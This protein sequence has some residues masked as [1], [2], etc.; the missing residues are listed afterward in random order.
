[1]VIDEAIAIGIV[2]VRAFTSDERDF[3]LRR[4][5][6]RHHASRDVLLILLKK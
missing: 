4:A 6:D 2:Q 5:V 3:G 1:V